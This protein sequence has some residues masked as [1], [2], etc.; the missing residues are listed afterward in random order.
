MPIPCCRLCYEKYL[1][2]TGEVDVNALQD[3]LIE[4]GYQRDGLYA[5]R[6]AEHPKL[7]KCPCHRKSEQVLH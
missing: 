3:I 7:C 4:H 5:K 1:H 6:V 2:D